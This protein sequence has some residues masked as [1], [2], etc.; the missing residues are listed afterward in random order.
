MTGKI[1]R[2]PSQIREQVNRRL[3]DGQPDTIILPWLNGLPEVQQILKDQF[4]GEPITEQNLSG[5]RK[6]AFR[7]WQLR[8]QALDF[9]A[10]AQ[11][12][13]RAAA[14]N[15][16]AHL[17]DHLVQYATLRFAAAAQSTPIPDDPELDLRQTH[18]LVADVV[19]LRRGD[20][21]AKRIAL[22]LKRLALEENQAQEHLEKLFW[23][24][25]KRPDINK[26][27][28]PYHDPDRERRAVVRMVDKALFGISPRDDDPE[29]DPAAW[30]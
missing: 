29:P 22:E 2:L 11:D 3:A 26:R 10:E 6:F 27:L 5:Y 13:S 18:R 20:L 24:W 25:T 15:G 19:A 7:R 4:G 8:Q 23:E 21:A 9:A 1:S 28:Y 17:G 14:Q 16:S 30:I 12:D